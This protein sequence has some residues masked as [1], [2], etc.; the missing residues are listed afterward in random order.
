MGFLHK[1][2]NVFVK[3]AKKRE[4]S[5]KRGSTGVGTSTKED[6]GDS[7][8][9]QRTG[10]QVVRVAIDVRDGE[11]LVTGTNV[12]DLPLNGH[13]IITTVDLPSNNDAMNRLPTCASLIDRKHPRVMSNEE[14]IEECLDLRMRWDHCAYNHFHMDRDEMRN[15]W[16]IDP[17]I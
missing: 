15:S 3:R 9:R 1:L 5:P 17:T 12:L 14:L 4:Q 11:I 6:H 10:V 13:E 2:K 8:R 7:R 16:T